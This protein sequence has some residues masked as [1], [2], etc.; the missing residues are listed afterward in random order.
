MRP[1]IGDHMPLSQLY[2]FL[3]KKLSVES[4][5]DRIE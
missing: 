2:V 4:V 3:D 5:T 1:N